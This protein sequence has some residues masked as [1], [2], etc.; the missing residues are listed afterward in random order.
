[1]NYQ[2]LIEK[3]FK[4]TKRETHLFLLNKHSN[5]ADS[6]LAVAVKEVC[7]ANWTS[8]PITA[9]KAAAILDALLKLN[10]ESEIKALWFWVSG[11][12]EITKGKFL[13]AIKNFDKSA[14][15]FKKIKKEHDAAQ[16]QVAKLYALALLGRYD[17]AVN[18]GN[19]ALKV[20]EKYNDEISAGKIENNIGNIFKRQQSFRDAEKYYLSARNR[21]YRL[22]NV[23]E[24]LVSEIGLAN[25]YTGLNDF[26][27]AEKYYENTLSTAQNLGMLVRQAEIETNIGNLALFRGKYDEALKNL[28]LSRQK[29][30]SLNMPHQ[31]AIAELEI[32]D[33]YLEIN[34]VKEAVLIYEKVSDKLH[35]L[36]LQGEEARARANFGR[37]AAIL[38]EIKTARRELKKSTKL[39][40]AEK[41]PVGAAAVKLNE[42]GLEL[43]LQNYRKTHALAV[44]A[45]KLLEKSENVRHKLT[46]RWLRA[47]ALRNLGDGERAKKLFAQIFAEAVKQEQPNLA[48]STQISLGKL[49]VRQKNFAQAERHFKK[50]IDLVETLRAPLPAE[51]FRMAFLADKLEP[52]EQLAKIYLARGKASEAF[53]YI[54]RAKSRSLADALNGDLQLSGEEPNETSAILSGKLKKLR[55]ELNWF[56]SRIS[57]ADEAEIKNLQAEAK[58]RE[59]RIADVMRQI[60]STGAAK[61]AGQDF[62][63]F[64]R[65]QKQL[66]KEKVLIEFVNFAGVLSAFVITNTQISFAANLAREDEIV[67]LL[68][69][70]QFQ[71]GSLRYGAAAVGKFAGELKKRA[72][73]YLQR[74]YE[75]LLKPLENLIDN[76]NFVI[77]PVGALHY[78]PFHALHDGESYAVEK[79][80]T[81]YAPSATVWQKLTEKP[82]QANKN[83][84]LIGF[85]D[86]KIPLVNE[87]IKTLKKIFRASKSFLGEQATFSA[88]T[89][90]ASEFEILHLACHGQFRPENP[91][92]SSLRLADGWITVKDICSQ[93]LKAEIVT[94]SACE[95]GFNK[96]F[97]GDEILGLARGFLSAGASSLVLSLWTVNDGAALELMKNFYENLQRGETVSASLRISQNEFIKRGVH[98]YFW[99]P[100]AVIGR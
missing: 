58:K 96:I 66:G 6:N 92:F 61:F 36:R 10:K 39:F 91:L 55:E 94:L 77:I 16:G 42:A 13:S 17:E 19:E 44:E 81:V 54:E 74:L 83:A 79:R 51:E 24:L 7:Y 62:L 41:N 63:D 70:L 32:A 69:A 47:E 60:E 67:E 76:K 21:F 100:F 49:A 86:E 52:F 75:K 33:I 30:E 34:L 18:C 93:R 8:N 14:E 35:K 5:L 90:N 22:N 95:T 27:E 84:L 57:R 85:A 48:Q 56:Y 11:I 20:F 23:E 71:F 73:F 53:L 26:C 2:N 1:M 40:A 25:T 97:P 98:P 28:E 99:S 38:R 9:R 65:L 46:A 29:Y 89:Q 37:G 64:A 50:A 72:D 31:T 87:E 59:K 12:S 88:F 68:E 43:N 15:I 3:L 80:E 45:E 4:T 82:L 78:V